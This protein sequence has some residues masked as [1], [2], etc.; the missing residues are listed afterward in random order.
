MTSSPTKSKK[1]SKSLV[2]SDK[3]EIENKKE[4]D[5]VENFLKEQKERVNKIFE[6]RVDDCLEFKP[7]ESTA[8]EWEEVP[9]SIVKSIWQLWQ[10]S[11]TTSEYLKERSKEEVTASLRTYAEARM[12]VSF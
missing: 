9:E 2:I 11:K 12:T 5:M 6:F 4:T 8:D 10:Q 7:E 3:Q 1:T